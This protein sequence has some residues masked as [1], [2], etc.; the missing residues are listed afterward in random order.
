MNR[1]EAD[2]IIK[3]ENKNVWLR[4]WVATASTELADKCLE[5][6]KNRFQQK[7]GGG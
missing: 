3:E 6:Y 7:E 4:A 5:D 2:L 1:V